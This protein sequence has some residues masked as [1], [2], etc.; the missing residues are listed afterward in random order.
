MYHIL[1]HVEITLGD[2]SG[3]TLIGRGVGE[4]LDIQDKCLNKAITAA[5][6]YWLIKTFLVGAGEDADSG[7]KKGP[8]RSY[9][10]TAP[11]ITTDRSV[12]ATNLLP[13]IER[14]D[15]ETLRTIASHVAINQKQGE[16]IQA[17]IK[18]EKRL[19]RVQLEA[20]IKKA[21]LQILEYQAANPLDDGE[22]AKPAAL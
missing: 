10:V 5:V 2:D 20:T 16:F 22:D 14:T 8:V 6:K 1:A 4:A 3:A 12:V 19:T 17:V 9:P 18:G 13:I 11:E 7:E 15:Q 21:W